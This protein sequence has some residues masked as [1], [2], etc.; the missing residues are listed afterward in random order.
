MLFWW[1]PP[2]IWY[3]TWISYILPQACCIG[4][5]RVADRQYADHLRI[6]AIQKMSVNECA[7]VHTWLKMSIGCW[8]SICAVRLVL[9]LSP[10]P[11]QPF[12]YR[13]LKE[14]CCKSI[15]VSRCNTATAFSGTLYCRDHQLSWLGFTS[16]FKFLATWLSPFPYKFMRGTYLDSFAP[17]HAENP[18]MTHRDLCPPAAEKW[19]ILWKDVSYSCHI[20][21]L[22]HFKCDITEQV[23]KLWFFTH[24]L[25]L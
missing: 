7:I 3:V 24:W 18:N 21:Y 20:P 16:G 17:I 11:G 8:R 25:T 23:Y 19:R 6:Y 5:P 13:R 2:D 10:R 22:M 14:T 12:C 15:Y 4:F 9:R 1:S